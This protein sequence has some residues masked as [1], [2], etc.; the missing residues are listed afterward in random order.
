MSPIVDE[1]IVDV[2]ARC[3]EVIERRF[4]EAQ[5]IRRHGAFV[6]IQTRQ[7]QN[8]KQNGLAVGEFLIPDELSPSLERGIDRVARAQFRWVE[9]VKHHNFRIGLCDGNPVHGRRLIS[10]ALDVVEG[11]LGKILWSY[12]RLDDGIFHLAFGCDREANTNES[13]GLIFRPAPNFAGRKAGVLVDEFCR[14]PL[15][16]RRLAVQYGIGGKGCILRRRQSRI[17]RERKHQGSK[18]RRQVVAHFH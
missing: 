7:R 2:I 12:Q 18:A 13:F 16:A 17:G 6:E 9:L 14:G 1:S 3:G 8:R 11:V 5:K 4:G 15:P 10:P